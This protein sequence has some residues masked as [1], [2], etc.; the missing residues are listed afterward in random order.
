M[1]AVNVLHDDAAH[2]APEL[3]VPDTQTSSRQLTC[4]TH[5]APEPPVLGGMDMP[6]AFRYRELLLR[7]RP[8]HDRLDAFRI[9]HPQM[10]IGR[11]AKIFAPFDALQ[12]FDEAIEKTA[13][14]AASAQGAV[15]HVTV[16]D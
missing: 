14:R 2:A 7:G 16:P 10:D 1:T 6:P 3:P 9:R 5:T 12:G 4:N 11:R 15:Q 13:A 8:R